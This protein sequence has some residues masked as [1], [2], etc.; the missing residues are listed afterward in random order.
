MPSKRKSIPINTAMTVLHESGYMCANPTC[1]T[2]MTLDMHHMEYVSEGGSNDAA[3]LLPLCPNCHALH[4]QGVIPAASV[5]AWKMLLVTLNEGFDRA[6]VSILLMLDK[7]NDVRVSGDG[8]L[9]CA[10]L[11]ASGLVEIESKWEGSSGLFGWGE[12]VGYFVQLSEKGR[13]FVGAWKRGDQHAAV[14]AMANLSL[15]QLRQD[16]Q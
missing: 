13:L 6:S 4:H 16:T 15:K 12:V 2:I 7:M 11:I 1:R 3:N 10:P 9:E 5:R 8:L 14:L